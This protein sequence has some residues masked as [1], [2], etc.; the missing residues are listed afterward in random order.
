MDTLEYVR[1]NITFRAVIEKGCEIATEATILCHND[2]I[3]SRV[4]EVLSRRYSVN[5]QGIDGGLL[6]SGED[7]QRLSKALKRGG[8]EWPDT[9]QVSL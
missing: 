9:D 2:K 8:F 1:R 3:K 6:I 4:D 5:S 7:F